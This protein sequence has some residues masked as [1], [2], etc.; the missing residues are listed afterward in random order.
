[1]ETMSLF[2]LTEVGGMFFFHPITDHMEM[3]LH[4]KLFM[5]QKYLEYNFCA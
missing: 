1:M 3:V 2:D 4:G 5:I